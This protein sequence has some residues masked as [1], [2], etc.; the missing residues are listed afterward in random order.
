MQDVLSHLATMK[1]PRLL[2]RAARLGAPDYRRET[3]LP[4]ILGVGRPPRSGPA[5]LRL[6]E[7]ESDLN[8]LRVE[9]DASYSIA[10]HVDVL[11]AMVAEAR[12]LRRTPPRPRL[13]TSTYPDIPQPVLD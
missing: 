3:H 13:V 6:S 10:R 4:R 12:L 8:H 5:L 9:N 11:I 1:R 7:L 2:V